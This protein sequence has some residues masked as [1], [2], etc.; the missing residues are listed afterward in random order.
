VAWTDEGTTPMNGHGRSDGPI[1][2]K[3]CA[4][5]ALGAPDVAECMEGRGPVKGNLVWQNRER[6]QSRGNLQQA[7]D[8]IRQAAEK[9]KEVRFTALWHHVYSEETLEQA[10]YGVKRDA[11]AG[12]D[13]ETWKTYGEDLEGNLRDL[14]GRLKRGAYRARPV[15]RAYVPKRDG[16]QRPIG[17]PSLEDKVVQ[18]ATV[19]VLNAIYETM[20]KGFSYGFRP[21][22]GAHDALDALS[23]GLERRKVNWVLDA[24]IRGFFDTIDHEWM[25]KFVEHRIADHR[26]V[27][28]IKKWLKAGVM[29]KGQWSGSETGTPQGGSISP[30][31]A[32]IYL[33]Y[34]LDL[35]VAQW[36][37]KQAKGEV[38]LVRYADDFVVGF[39]YKQDAERFLEQ[40][41]SRL[42]QFG[43]HL[44]SEKTRL[45]EFGRYAEQDRNK[46]GYRKPETFEFL[47]FTHICS[48]N[49]KGKFCVL[50]QTSR[51]RMIAKLHEIKAQLKLWMHARVGAVGEWLNRVV[52]GYYRYFAVPRNLHALITFRQAVLRLWRQVLRRRSQ[53][54]P[55]SW[56][57]HCDINGRWIPRPRVMHPYP[58][59]RLRV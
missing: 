26:V 43:L 42:E 25:V 30:L 52:A 21:G 15:R 35:W 36:R 37:R 39:Q 53:K 20:F 29:E 6:T 57:E 48:Q 56:K 5:K 16:R 4:N 7:L 18:R 34:V 50:R 8:R 27:R 40:L 12:V 41:R 46:R 13:G 47:G 38:I 49:R 17:V 24:D 9:D 54:R 45:I 59:Q 28:H 2:P 22:R 1:V 51:K 19:Q 32:N 11:G 44:H 58:G 10:Y 3:K 23:V 31:L 33:H 14:S 55:L